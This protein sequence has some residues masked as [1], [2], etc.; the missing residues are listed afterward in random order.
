MKP[1]SDRFRLGLLAVGHAVTDTYGHSLLAP[2]YPELRRRLSLSLA[3]V[4]GLP[5][6]LGLTASL[7]QPLLGWL[8][9]RYPRVPL[10]ALGPLCAALF[11]GLIGQ[12][13]G[14]WQLAALLFLAGIGIGAYH[15]QGAS[16]ARLAGRG[17]GLAMSAFTVGGNIGFGLAPILG[18]LYAG[19]FGLAHFYWAALP[20]VAFASVRLAVFY[21]GPGMHASAAVA[22][23]LASDHASNH[24]ALACLT[25][26]V[27]VRS[28]VQVGMTTF[29]P[30][31]V[32]AR[33]PR[34]MH[35]VV[36]SGSLT[37][38]LLSSAVAGPIGGHLADRF[39]HRAVML[40]SFL[41]APRPLLLGLNTPGL[42]MIAFLAAGGFLLMLPHP[43]NVLMAQ[44]LLPRSAGIGASLITGLAAGLAQLL[45]L[46]LGKAADLTSPATALAGLSLVPLLGIPLLAPIPDRPPG[47]QPLVTPLLAENSQ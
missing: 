2:L 16:L 20:A 24:P 25:A 18:V 34:E 5:V 13:T 31:L 28:A 9:D 41:L 30:F 6:M 44:E 35:G 19:W 11:I 33:F 3:E 38:F 40:W 21:S 4:G 14:Y 26:T 8:S 39:G 43:S 15:P 27:V 10:V 47:A 7:A 12:A 17:S 29:L 46:P 32:E 37:A 45:A 36:I 1:A 42:G 23:K 22:R